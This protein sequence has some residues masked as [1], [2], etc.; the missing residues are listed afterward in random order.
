MNYSTK[1][2]SYGPSRSHIDCTREFFLKFK[3][4]LNNGLMKYVN[5]SGLN[6]RE[7][8]LDQVNLSDVDLTDVNLSFARLI[9]VNLDRALLTKSYFY[10]A[11]VRHASLRGASFDPDQFNNVDLSYYSIRFLTPKFDKD[12][13]AAQLDFLALRRLDPHKHG[14]I[15]K[16]L[17]VE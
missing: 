1:V 7:M 5:L 10:K 2:F 11:E 16:S 13:L 14:L 4:T 3:G 17:V 6:F 8:D 15:F 12:S 9:N